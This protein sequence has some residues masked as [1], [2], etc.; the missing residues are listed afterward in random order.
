MHGV[1]QMR[2]SRAILMPAEALK[3]RECEKEDKTDAQDL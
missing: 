2:Q 1:E 3:P